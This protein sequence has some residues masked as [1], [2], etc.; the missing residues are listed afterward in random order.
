MK[1]K[2]K[3]EI[4]LHHIDSYK[5]TI[6][7]MIKNNTNSLVDDDIMSLIRKPPLDSMDL[8]QNKFLSLAKKNKVILN[9]EELNRKIKEYR[10]QV[11]KVSENLKKIRIEE[12]SKKVNN[13]KLKDNEII[14]I[15]K[16]DLSNVNKEMKKLIKEKVSSSIEKEIL[17]N[18]NSI[19]TKEV[20]SNIKE[21]IIVEI[22]KYLKKNYLNQLIESIDIKILVKDTTLINNSKEQAERYLFTLS[23]SRLLNELD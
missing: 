11:M 22:T 7:E 15:N 1:N 17:A 14:K 10:N 19:F 2:T 5:S 18:V 6:I 21:K 12:L 20:D 3:D 8:I 13:T 4:K 23:N 16:K 9:S